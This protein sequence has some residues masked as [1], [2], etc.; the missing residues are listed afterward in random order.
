MRRMIAIL[1]LL[2]ANIVL[3]AHSVVPHHH[4]SNDG[5]SMV[6]V[7]CGGDNDNHLHNNNIACHHHESHNDDIH[8]SVHHHE[9][10]H[11]GDEYCVLSSFFNIKRE[12]SKGINYILL[13]NI[14]KQHSI[15]ICN[16]KSVKIIYVDLAEYLYRSPYLISSPLRGPP[17]C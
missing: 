15:S 5:V 12:Y 11:N 10:H 7:L 2:V 9:S 4:H 6:V 14:V 16:D 8:N 1:M 13:C 17:T 3:F